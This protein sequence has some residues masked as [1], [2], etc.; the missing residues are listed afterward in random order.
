TR[1]A[2]LERTAPR[3]EDLART[4][5]AEPATLDLAVAPGAIQWR[6][7]WTCNAGTLQLSAAGDE[8]ELLTD[9]TCPGQGEAFSIQTGRLQ[10]A[11]EA[12]G[13]WTVTV[14]Q[15]VDTPI[16]EPP[17]PDMASSPV[18]A[19]GSFYEIDK[20][21]EGIARL[22]ALPDGGAALRFEDFSVSTNT[23]LFVWLSE[24][25]RPQTSAEAFRAPHVQIAELKS[26][27]GPQNYLVPLDLP[28][29]RVRSVVI[30]CE[31]VQVAYI[32]AGLAR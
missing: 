25:E 8:S 7:R 4:G 24:A 28:L 12:T 21:G 2:A 27:V 29:E 18:V 13:P 5:G 9:S 17:L 1:G 26:T 32:A 16:N 6:V 22:Y 10:L 14:Q 31:P 20:P 19:Q 3:W 23:D 11:V 30:W 15:Q